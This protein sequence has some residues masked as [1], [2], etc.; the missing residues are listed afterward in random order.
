[1]FGD[2]LEKR[3]LLEEND[4]YQMKKSAVEFDTLEDGSLQK[5]RSRGL[6]NMEKVSW[7]RE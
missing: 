5:N 4:H 7:I 6:E 1:M 3:F 2:F